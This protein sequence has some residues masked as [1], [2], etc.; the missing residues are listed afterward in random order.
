MSWSRQLSKPMI[1]TTISKHTNGTLRVSVVNAQRERP[2]NTTRIA[3][4]ARCAIQRLGIAAQGEWSITFVDSQR[5]RQLNKRF[6]RHDR[7]TDVLSFR[8]DGEPTVGEILIAPDQAH[9]Y[10][11]QH[12]LSYGEELS[13]YVVHGL[14]HWL[15]HDDRTLAQQ[16]KMRALEDKLLYTVNHML[17]SC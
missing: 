13:R 14:L 10:A 5:M 7:P 11:K 17:R 9:A 3:R 6:M 8:Y 12:G 4:V 1:G 15:G 16:R 2:V